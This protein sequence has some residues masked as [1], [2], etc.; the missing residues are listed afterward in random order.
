MPITCRLKCARLW[1]FHEYSTDSDFKFWFERQ[2]III[3]YQKWTYS[4]CIIQY[5]Q[6]QLPLFWLITTIQIN[7]LKFGGLIDQ[8]LFNQYLSQLN[9]WNVFSLILHAKNGGVLIILFYTISK[10][11][12][13]LRYCPVPFRPVLRRGE[14]MLHWKTRLIRHHSREC[15]V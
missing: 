13:L 2:R 11:G 3:Y 8:K 9:P 4:I 6:V 10:D 14:S 5:I 12:Q 7:R 15:G 1:S